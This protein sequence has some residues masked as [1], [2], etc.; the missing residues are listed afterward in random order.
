MKIWSTL[1][2]TFIALRIRINNLR[3]CSTQMQNHE[4]LLEADS[5]AR[6]EQVRS[7]IGVGLTE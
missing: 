3:I 2:N 1:S 6:P 5:G 7:R 4:E